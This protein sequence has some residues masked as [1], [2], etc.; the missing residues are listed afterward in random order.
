MSTDECFLVQN[1]QFCPFM[2]GMYSST[3]Y[4][5]ADTKSLDKFLSVWTNTSKPSG[6]YLSIFQT[7]YGCPRWDGNGFRY[8]QSVTCVQETSDLLDCNDGELPRLCKS[9]IDIFIQSMQSLFNNGNYC[10]SVSP[11]SD[12]GYQRTSLISY[13]QDVSKSF[14]KNVRSSCIAGNT[15]E[16]SQCGK[17]M[18]IHIARLN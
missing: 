4:D 9:S 1:S 2:N 13:Y 18:D 15:N 12:I 11:Y 10:V 14:E 7:S 5:Y 16:A 6:N 3:Y 17:L 8:F